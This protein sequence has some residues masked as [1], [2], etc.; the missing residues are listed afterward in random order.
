MVVTV[1][2][3]PI[4]WAFLS[5]FWASTNLTKQSET[6]SR[7]QSNSLFFSLLNKNYYYTVLLSKEYHINMYSVRHDYV[8]I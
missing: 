1:T 5:T 7:N 8:I 6:V 3:T 4:P 2:E